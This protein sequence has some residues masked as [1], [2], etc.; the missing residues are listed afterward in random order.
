MGSFA[1]T[2]YTETVQ[3]LVQGSQ[4]RLKNPYYLFS[5]KSP[6]TV[7]YYNINYKTLEPKNGRIII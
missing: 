3:S 4:D 1:N 6:T 7:T 5:N 2:H